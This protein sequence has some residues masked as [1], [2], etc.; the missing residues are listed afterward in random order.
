MNERNENVIA[1]AAALLDMSNRNLQT[2]IKNYERRV[3]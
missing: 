3:L 2:L 1:N